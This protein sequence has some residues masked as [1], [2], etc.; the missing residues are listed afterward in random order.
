MCNIVIV[1][2]VIESFRFEDKNEQVYG[3]SLKVFVHVLKQRHPRKLQLFT[4]F[5]KKVS[6]VTE[7]K[8]S[9][10]GKMIGGKRALPPLCHPCP[11]WQQHNQQQNI[12]LLYLHMPHH[13]DIS[14]LFTKNGNHC[15]NLTYSTISR[16][17][18]HYPTP[19]CS[20]LQQLSYSQTSVQRSPLGNDKVTV[21][22]RAVMYRFDCTW[23][24]ADPAV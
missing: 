18:I 23:L 8:P 7:D 9:P 1:R 24:S 3:I 16:I 10:N 20:R 17:C 11:L 22:Y 14:V 21:V 13:G 19:E 2:S 4:F 6:T 15:F 12:M 5:T